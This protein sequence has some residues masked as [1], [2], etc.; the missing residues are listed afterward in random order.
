VTWEQPGEID[1]KVD[2]VLIDDGIDGA[3]HFVPELCS[4]LR[5]AVVVGLVLTH[6]HRRV[7]QDRSSR[8]LCSKHLFKCVCV[9]VCVCVCEAKREGRA[10]HLLQVEHC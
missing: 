6:V 1:A 9:C 7:E 10:R 2:S 4:E 8:R 3:K 5:Q